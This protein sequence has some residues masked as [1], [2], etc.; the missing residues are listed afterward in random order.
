MLNLW[1][2][3]LNTASFC[4]I[5]DK[6]LESIPHALFHCN[7][8][9]QTWSCWSDCPVNL[10][11]STQDFIGITFQIMEK[12]SSTDLD[13]FFM[14]AWS[15]WG[16]RNNATHNDAN[17]PSTQVWEIAKRSLI[18]FTTSNLP[19]HPSHPTVR[20]HWF[21]PSLGFHKINV[22]EAIAN[23]VEHSNIGVIIQDHIEATIRAFDEQLPSAFPTS[24]T[25]A[26]ALLQ[27]VLF[28]AKM[29]STKAIFESDALALI[30]A[31]NSNENGG[32]LGHIL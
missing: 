26:F 23:N 4:Q 5:R 32:V 30:Q 16:K 22:D 10:Y 20:A 21:P 27:G 7:H 6:D 31:V 13:L 9:K 24:I 28:A 12:G 8:A 29:G 2:R 17:C 19:N 25:E 15:I 1:R 3:G 11:S 14:A 18:D